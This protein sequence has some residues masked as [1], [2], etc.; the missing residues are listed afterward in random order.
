MLAV[1]RKQEILD[2]I[3]ENKVCSIDKLASRFGVS[4]V[5]VHRI[6]NGLEA[7]EL[8]T[9]VHGGVRLY[10]PPTLETRFSIR[11]R[12]N[13]EQKEQIARKA[14]RYV[15][16]G[17]TIYVDS[18][19]TCYQLVRAL[20]RR[21][22]LHVTVIS[23]SPLVGYELAHAPHISLI[24]TGGE[25][26]QEVLTF[27]GQLTLEAI[28]RLQFEKAFVSAGAVALDRGL[29][30][31]KSFLADIIRQ[32]IERAREVN[33]LVDSSKFLRLAAQV[34]APVTRVSRI[35]SDAGLPAGTI[36]GLRALGVE[37]VV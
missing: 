10:E 14:L 22:D 2:F 20:R 12:T 6:L 5:T 34:I 13:R 8:V 3:R 16:D 36:E 17:D 4:R 24:S 37:V 26:D 25:L 21:P 28:A 31:S 18:S 7:E 1:E 35:I 30:T 23:S 19:T 32:A 29:M 33:L 9:K 11:L 15:A 27:A